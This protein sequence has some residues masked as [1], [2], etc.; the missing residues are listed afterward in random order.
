[1]KIARR[2]ILR[3][4]MTIFDHF[5]GVLTRASL[6]VSLK[7]P[8]L[9]ILKLND[10]FMK[11]REVIITNKPSNKYANNIP[12]V[13]YDIYTKMNPVDSFIPTP[14]RSIIRTILELEIHSK[15][16]RNTKLSDNIISNAMD[17]HANCSTEL[18]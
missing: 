8:V 7:Y 4:T 18:S 14:T 13:P 9:S 12:S 3:M 17:I 10:F 6:I 15:P 1:M 2:T 11:Y 16:K 5:A